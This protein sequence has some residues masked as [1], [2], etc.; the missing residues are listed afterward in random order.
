[1]SIAPRTGRGILWGKHCLVY[2]GPERCDCGAS[3]TPAQYAAHMKEEAE[4]RRKEEEKR[5]W[6]KKRKIKV[7]RA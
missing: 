2:C 5:T 7:K 4:Q 3:A 1:M 6:P